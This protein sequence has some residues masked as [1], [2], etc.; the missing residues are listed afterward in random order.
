MLLRFLLKH[1]HLYLATAD[2]SHFVI[3]DMKP[4]AVAI[5]NIKQKRIT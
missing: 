1:E 5:T 3:V 2:D 4:Y